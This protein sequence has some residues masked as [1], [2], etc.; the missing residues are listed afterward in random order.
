MSLLPDFSSS[1][2][3]DLPEFES[4]KQGID[5]LMQYLGPFSDDLSDHE[6]YLN[7]RW[8]EVRDDVHFQEAVLHV[9]KESGE[10]LNILDG[11]ISTGKWEN[12]LNGLV[13]Q[14][15]R[16]HELYELVFLNANFF[17]LTK[18]GEHNAK[19]PGRQYLFLASEGY[20]RS[21]EWPQLLEILYAY[22]KDNSSYKT[23]VAGIVL[24]VLIIALL[25]IL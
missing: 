6:L 18:H 7:R 21:L 25:S 1:S 13:L 15:G 24:I 22:Y 11:D 5:Y 12:D 16:D 14:F 2:D 23:I 19:G 8:M 20:A 17:I 9:F 4:L 10:Y 3:K